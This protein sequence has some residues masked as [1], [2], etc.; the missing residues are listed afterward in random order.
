MWALSGPGQDPDRRGSPGE[1]PGCPSPVDPLL[2][3]SNSLSES[4][5]HEALVEILLLGPESAECRLRRTFFV[6]PSVAMRHQ[7][8]PVHEGR[9]R[10]REPGPQ[11]VED[12]EAV[13]VDVAPRRE[14]HVDQPREPADPVDVEPL[15][16]DDD[17]VLGNVHAQIA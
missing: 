13:R 14:I 3:E 7:S 6:D 12:G 17:A 8:G 9:L 11:A 5:R 4:I 10:L 15:A 16:P 2:L 1:S